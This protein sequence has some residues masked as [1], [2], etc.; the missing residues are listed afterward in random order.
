MCGGDPHSLVEVT[1]TMV[2]AGLEELRQHHY[3]DDAAL[4]LESVFRAMDYARR[5]ASATSASKYATAM[6][7]TGPG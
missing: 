6:R 7:A 4:M 3:D 2:A 1:D 5:S